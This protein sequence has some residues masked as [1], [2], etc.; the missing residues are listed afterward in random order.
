[1]V[2]DVLAGYQEEREAVNDHRLFSLVLECKSASE[3]VNIVLETAFAEARALV[4]EAEI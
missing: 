4:E 1:M 3:Q 2:I